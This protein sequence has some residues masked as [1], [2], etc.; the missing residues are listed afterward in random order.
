MS[1]S[2]P[3]FD[4]GRVTD[5]IIDQLLSPALLPKVLVGDAV[6]PPEGGWPSGVPG[7]GN[8]VP[9]TVLSTGQ[10]TPDRGTVGAVTPD[11]W[12]LRYQLKHSG[13]MRQ[14]VDW[15]AD[16]VRHA[17]DVQP[18]VRLDMGEGPQWKAYQFSVLTMGP[19][20]R[21][22]TVQPPYWDVVDDV[23]LTLSRCRT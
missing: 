8:F 23:A 9:Y 6:A 20:V 18:E 17:W 15:T 21:N 2:K 22:D 19:V 1:S 12:I 4:R 16:L 7:G 13:G 3:L 10:A 14:M 11:T 5:W